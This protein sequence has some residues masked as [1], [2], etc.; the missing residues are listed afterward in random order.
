MKKIKI[1]NLAPPTTTAH[2]SVGTDVS[3][4]SKYGQTSLR[5]TGST[6]AEVTSPSKNTIPLISTHKYYGR[7]EVY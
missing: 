2:F 4:P 7:V 1:T 3:S 5:I 6:K